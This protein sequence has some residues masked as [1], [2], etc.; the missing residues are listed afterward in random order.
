[1]RQPGQPFLVSARRLS[2]W[3]ECG[4]AAPPDSVLVACSLCGETL[5]ISAQAAQR[6]EEERAISGPVGALCTE[7][8]LLMIVA[9]RGGAAEVEISD[10]GMKVLTRDD[11]A[12][13][14]ARVII[15]FLTGEDV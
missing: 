13:E 12:G 8:C 3:A 9:S 10:R 2:N 7:P 5:T 4:Q 6:L 14:R 11:P 15:R 1:M